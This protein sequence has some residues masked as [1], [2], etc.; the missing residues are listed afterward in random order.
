[1]IVDLSSMITSPCDY[2]YFT[3][4]VNDYVRNIIEM[5]DSD[6]SALAFISIL[7]LAIAYTLPVAARRV[8]GNMRDS[9]SNTSH[10]YSSY[11]FTS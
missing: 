2:H 11:L 5:R 8:Y 7:V 1:M 10:W 3:T 4:K 9:V 6:I